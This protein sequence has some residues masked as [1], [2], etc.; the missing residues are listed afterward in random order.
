M[1]VRFTPMGA[2][3]F[4]RLPM[5]LIR[6]RAVDM[7][8]LDPKLAARVLSLVGSARSWNQR[9]DVIEA[10]VA[11]R[12]AHA[13][14]SSA[15]TSAWRRLEASDGRV[16][17]GALA[18]EVDCSHRALI[19]QFRT[20]VGATP[21]AVGRLFRFNRAIRTLDGFGRRAGDWHQPFIESGAAGLGPVRQTPWAD[22]A[23]DCGY[24][25]QAHFIREFRQFAGVTPIE[26]LRSMADVS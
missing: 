16:R 3:H 5:H 13:P 9:F 11:E 18:S 25:D 21:K 12:L 24:S 8:A 4:L 17:I 26:F 23:A 1:V 20:C 7:S 10:L 14:L 2:H 19:D 6:D 22:V 15:F